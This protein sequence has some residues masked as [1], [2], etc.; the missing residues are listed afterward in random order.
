MSTALDK[1]ETYNYTDSY[2]TH[3]HSPM[4]LALSAGYGGKKILALRELAL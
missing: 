2:Y 4:H 3:T 1:K